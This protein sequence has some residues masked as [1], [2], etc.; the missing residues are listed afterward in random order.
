[1]KNGKMAILVGLLMMVT[2]VW[3]ADATANGQNGRKA[4]NGKKQEKKPA[5]VA[6]GDRVLA[7][8]DEQVAAWNSGDLEKF[9]R[10]YWRSPQ[11]TFYSSS[12]KL[13]GWDATLERY[14]K[15]YQADGR[16]MG[17][18]VFDDLD[19][20]ML[21]ADS[22]L[23]RGRWQLTFSDGKRMG[24]IYSLV[25]RRMKNEWKIIHDHTS[26]TEQPR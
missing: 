16:E 11:L 1:M 19:I 2:I 25:F 26:S 5:V 15:T 24:G 17:K 3:A 7:V 4:G 21:G 18:L 12:G 8:L 20:T 10:G 23:V 9:M 6:G 13:N 14:R 22:A